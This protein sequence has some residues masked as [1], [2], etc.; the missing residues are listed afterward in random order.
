MAAH[1]AGLEG[2]WLIFSEPMLK[3]IREHFKLPD[4]ISIVTYVDLGYGDQTPYPVLRPKVK[5]IVLGR[6]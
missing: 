1:A 6:C 5:D 3:R 2:V 4:Y